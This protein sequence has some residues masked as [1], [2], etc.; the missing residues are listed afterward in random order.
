MLDGCYV[1][2]GINRGLSG[3]TILLEGLGKGWVVGCWTGLEGKGE[4][5]YGPYSAV[6]NK[7]VSVSEKEHLYEVIKKE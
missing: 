4:R 6:R 2:R 3:S 5:V 7:D 1:T